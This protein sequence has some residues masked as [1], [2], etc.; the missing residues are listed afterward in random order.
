MTSTPEC[1]WSGQDLF[2]NLDGEETGMPENTHKSSMR[3]FSGEQK[4]RCKASMVPGE[5]AITSWIRI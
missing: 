1:R 2:E 4:T 5:L 3:V